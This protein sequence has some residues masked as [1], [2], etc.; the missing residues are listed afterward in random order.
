MT[1]YATGGHHVSEREFEPITLAL[2]PPKPEPER[3]V[4]MPKKKEVQ[5]DDWGAP[6]YPSDS[7]DELEEKKKKA[8]A[9]AAREVDD[10]F[11]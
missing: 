5:Y 11:S 10:M 3:R 1:L 8:R 9:K 4:K 7:D 2:S 6:Y